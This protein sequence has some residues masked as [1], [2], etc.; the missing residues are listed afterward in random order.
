[1]EEFINEAQFVFGE[2]YQ[3]QL[4]MRNYRPNQFNEKQ[5][6]KARER[7]AFFQMMTMAR[8][9]NRRR[10]IHWGMIQNVSNFARGVST[11]AEKASAYFGNSVSSSTRRRHF[12][13]LTDNDKEERAN[14]NT[15]KHKQARL[16]RTCRTV[17]LCYDNYKRG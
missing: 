1:M 12:T 5:R 9:T 4:S 10:L 13:R 6:N 14:G 16:L 17:I 8:Q 3:L 11:A 7:S 2:L 15:L